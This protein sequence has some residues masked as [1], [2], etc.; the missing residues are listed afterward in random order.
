M[1]MSNADVSLVRENFTN[2]VEN[3]KYTINSILC[4]RKINSKNPDANALEVIIKNY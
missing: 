1:M 3:K 2:C 4:K